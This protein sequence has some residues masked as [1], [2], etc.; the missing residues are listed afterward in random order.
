MSD[1]ELLQEW[2]GQQTE[3]AFAELVRRH[4]DL[5]YA[6][7]LRQVRDPELARDIS[8]AVFLALARKAGG[9]GRSVILSGWLF[10]TTCFIAARSL[11]TQARR[12]RYEQ[13]ATDMNSLLNNSGDSPEHWP[14][15]APHLDAA[16]AVLPASDRDAVVLR[17]LEHKTLRTVGERFGI[18]EEAAKKRVS[19]AVEKLRGALSKRGVMLAPVALAA[20][21]KEIPVEAAP[22]EV[23]HGISAAT[24]GSV[25]PS[26]STMATQGLRDLFVA[27]LKSVAPLAGLVGLLLLTGGI[28]WQKALTPHPADRPIL[29]ETQPA[30]SQDNRARP[31]RVATT[32]ETGAMPGPSRIVLSVLGADSNRPLIAS[33]RVNG[34]DRAGLD[35]AH[36]AQTDTHG[37]AEFSV[38]GTDVR[39]FQIWISAPGYVPVVVRWNQHEFVEPSLTHIARLQRGQ[40]LEGVVQDESSNPIS[41]AR[42]IFDSPGMNLGTR[43]NIG[44]HSRLTGL[45]TDEQGRFRCDQIPPL[46]TSGTM[47][48]AVDHTDFI[49]QKIVLAESIRT[50]HIVVL[51]RGLKVRGK[52]LDMDEQPVSGAKVIEYDHY[53][54]PHRSTETDTAGAFEIGPFVVGDIRLEASAEGYKE[55]NNRFDVNAKAT[56]LVIRLSRAT[57]E[58]SEWQQGMDAGSTVRITGKVTDADSNREIPRFS[59][60]LNEHRGGDNNF[61]GEGREGKFEWPIFMAFFQ[62]FS[63]E[64]EADGFETASTDLR[65]VEAGT[66]TFDIHLQRASAL[67]GRVLTPEG[68][69]VVGAWVG[70]NGEHSNWMLINGQRPQ[71]FNN[72]PHTST[73][74]DGRF[75]IKSN[76]GAESVLIEHDLGCSFVLIKDL[77]NPEV[78][79]NPWGAIEG[80]SVVNG[81]PAFGQSIMLTSATGLDVPGCINVQQSAVTDAE[82]RFR[83]ARVPATQLAVCRYWNFHR[84]KTGQTAMSHNQRVEVPAGAVAKVTLGSRGRM[85]IGRLVL[86][87][88]LPGH[89]WRDDLQVLGEVG[90]TQPPTPNDPGRHTETSRNFYPEIAPDG[91]FRIDDVDA[92]TYTLNLNVLQPPDPDAYD[93]LGN[94]IR[95]PRIGRKSL[96]VTV[97]EGD[98][99]EP[100]DLGVITIPVEKIPPSTQPK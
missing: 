6:S 5:V 16:L 4:V 51:K 64:V 30:A 34:S 3:S 49:R 89:D 95:R 50:N 53:S 9:I 86:S 92:G 28:L 29:P 38:N 94:P 36:D 56:N 47:G 11:R 2:A 55:A 91:T 10:R 63:L 27:R 60:R 21:L 66:Q 96:R 69:P 77:P 24:T 31:F 43:Q 48:Y 61:L 73:D 88:D 7:A 84:D 59:V 25:P 76:L 52:V 41:G 85:V 23:A 83:F 22:L 15:V 37:F 70:I 75:S 78:I 97:P 90:R 62:E 42:I 57:G 20:L 44:F 26:V 99:N 33:L 98:G 40:T 79:L 18:S 54:G 87:R 17:Y 1:W 32:T 58:H 81:Q 19:R 65:P 13:E 100:I 8:Q 80:I 93:P 39:L 68:T 46:S 67:S 72:A 82:G 12:Q 45:T 35:F 14:E 74:A 71:S